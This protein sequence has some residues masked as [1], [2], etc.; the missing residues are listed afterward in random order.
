MP[1]LVFFSKVGLRRAFGLALA[2]FPVEKTGESGRPAVNLGP[3]E[4]QSHVSFVEIQLSYQYYLLHWYFFPKGK[5]L[6]EDGELTSFAGRL[7]ISRG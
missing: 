2:L 3:L 1:L 7:L 6:E 5:R 4:D